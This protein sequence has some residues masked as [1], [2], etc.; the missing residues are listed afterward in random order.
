MQRHHY[1]PQFYLREWYIP[2]KSAFWLYCRDNAGRLLF[3]KKS[4]RSVGYQNG[5]Y[6]RIP[7]FFENQNQ[8]T[9]SIEENFFSPLDSKASKVI[10]KLIQ[11]GPQSLSKEDRLVWSIF[12]NSLLERSP[13]RIESI[14]NSAN[15]LAN[16]EFSK[17]KAV[18][19][20]QEG[21]RHAFLD[22]MDI[23]AIANNTVLAE[24]VK[25]ICNNETISHF[26][27]MTWMVARLPEGNDHFLTS[28][29]PVV[30]NGASG[31]NPIYVLSIALSPNALFIMHKQEKDFNEDFIQTLAIIHNHLIAE[32]TKRYLVSSRELI[33][34][35]NIKYKKIA[36]FLFSGKN[37]KANN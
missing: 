27:N 13:S 5:L 23:A 30:V 31:G 35:G 19:E 26:A 24:M 12:I 21:E 36:N 2:G 16:E 4:A 33:D 22:E 28:D 15:K 6:S 29:T 8:S 3:G 10:K 1:V 7:E 34:D 9:N 32:Q 20:V 11:S 14:K 25:W 37:H 18:H 17:I